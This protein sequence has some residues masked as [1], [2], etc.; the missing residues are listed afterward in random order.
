MN[1]HANGE[2]PDDR[3]DGV[4]LEL[5][6]REQDVKIL[7]IKSRRRVDALK[8]ITTGVVVTLIPAIISWQ[9]QNQQVE[10]ERVKSEQSYLKDF[11]E[12]ALQD[13]LHKRYN[14]ADYL[15]TVALSD[16]SRDRWNEY[17][18]KIKGLFD[19]QERL[20]LNIIDLKRRIDAELGKDDVDTQEIQDYRN[21]LMRAENALK[22]IRDQFNLLNAPVIAPSSDV[23]TE[24]YGGGTGIRFQ[25]RN[26]NLDEQGN[27]IWLKG[28]GEI[29]AT[30]E[31]NHDCRECGNAI[32]QIIVGIGGES[33][34]QACVWSGQQSSNGWQPASFS[35]KVPSAVGT[36][37][38]RT[39]YA[40]AYTCDDALGWWTV[41]RPDGPTA[42][43]DIGVVV[44]TGASSDG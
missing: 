17:R 3:L 40:Q 30:I 26:L 24:A 29:N 36:Y 6:R 15:A 14:F 1:D 22:Q 27:A 35:L 21:E 34:A 43:S 37:K 7:E 11:A 32:N 20:R 31:I 42:A 28:G 12:Q 44:V 2:K 13:D 38:I 25:V 16:Q 5:H 39:R 8:I 18:D 19:D 41:D 33:A 23:F 9:I 10:I 4:N